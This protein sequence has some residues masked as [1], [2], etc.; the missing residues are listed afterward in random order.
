MTRGLPILGLLL[1]SVAVCAK[2][3]PPP[4]PAT[5]TPQSSV[6]WQER[7][8]ESWPAGWG[9]PS[10]ASGDEIAQVYRVSS[11]DDQRFL[12]ARHGA[13]DE[14][15][16]P[17]VHWGKPWQERPIALTSACFLSWR[18][19]VQQHPAAT[20]PPW[21]DIAVSIYVVMS[22]PGLFASGR[23]FKFGW[24]NR[25]GPKDTKQRGLVQIALRSGGPTNTWREEKVDLC[26]LYRQHYGDPESE[27]LLYVGVVSD[28]DDTS[29]TAAGDYDDFVLMS[30]QKP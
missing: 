27:K 1:C 10:G 25:P 19:R 11:D 9:S 5:P 16:P 7:F 29:S 18:W 28:A 13:T 14:D 3:L 12:S 8:D 26:S 22:E 24:L 4:A 20:Q 15:A 21:D 23:G 6:L 17:A 30:D 2:P